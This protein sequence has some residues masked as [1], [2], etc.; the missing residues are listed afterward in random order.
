MF[1]IGFACG[2][3]KTFPIGRHVQLTMRATNASAEYDD[4]IIFKFRIVTA[5]AFY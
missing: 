3:L 2:F 5:A 1:S 4:V